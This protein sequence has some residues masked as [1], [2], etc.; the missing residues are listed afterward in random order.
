LIGFSVLVIV[1][2][3]RATSAA[4]GTGV[5]VFSAATSTTAGVG[6][7]V[8]AAVGARCAMLA[9][10]T[11]GFSA[12]AMPASG[13]RSDLSFSSS[14]S[15]KFGTLDFLRPRP[16]FALHSFQIKRPGFILSAAQAEILNS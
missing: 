11:F 15:I 1:A 13:L 7:G 4:G 6:G 16:F 9:V 8:V 12:A 2:V 5:T 3:G 10:V 14:R